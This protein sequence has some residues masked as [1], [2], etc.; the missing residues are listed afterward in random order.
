[1]AKREK[2][3]LFL[4]I[5][6]EINRIFS[7][8]QTIQTKKL[9]LS[10]EGVGKSISGQTPPSSITFIPNSTP[11]SLYFLWELTSE[12]QTLKD[13]VTAAEMAALRNPEKRIRVET[14]GHVRQ[15]AAQQDRGQFSQPTTEHSVKPTL[16]LRA[17]AGILASLFLGI[18][19]FLFYNLIKGSLCLWL[20][21]SVSPSLSLSMSLLCLSLSFSTRRVFP[22]PR[23]SYRGL[24]G[25]C[26]SGMGCLLN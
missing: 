14:P 8:N 1:M 12:T 25:F 18:L 6:M 15:K 19:F 7:Y 3:K 22:F 11:C 4:A 10:S 21:I 26:L 23:E 16:L 20:C 17:S 9:L 2:G 24:L 13:R 5:F